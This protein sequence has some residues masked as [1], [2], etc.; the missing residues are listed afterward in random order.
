L[1]GKH[2]LRP[3]EVASDLCCS[4]Y[5]FEEN[6]CSIVFDD[7]SISNKIHGDGRGGRVYEVGIAVEAGVGQNRNL[8]PDSEGCRAGAEARNRSLPH[9]S[10]PACQ[11][12]LVIYMDSEASFG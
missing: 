5:H 10:T 8:S 3:V 11:F 4:G 2:A 9:A 7:V 12:V 1:A 6:M